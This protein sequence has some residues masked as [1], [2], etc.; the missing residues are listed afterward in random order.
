MA[1]FLHIPERSGIYQIVNT[2]TQR[3]YVGYASNMRQ[4]LKG[5]YHELA[6]FKHKN[7]YLQRS[8]QKYGESCFSISVLQECEKDKLCF[9]EDYWI[10]TLKVCNRQYG[11]NI[12]D[13][14]ING[15]AGQSEET[16]A[17]LR[18]S[19]K[20]ARPNK[21]AREKANLYWKNNPMTDEHKEKLKKSRSHINWKELYRTKRGKRVI[22]IS[23][24]KIYRSLA[25]AA[26][27]IN[28]TKYKLCKYLLGTRTNKTT[29]RY[30]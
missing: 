7:E 1:T 9:Y 19:N 29:L 25:E 4:R 22:D 5:H 11:Y 12:K 18:I 2:I 26:E 14:N 10:K 28:M 6:R 21:E 23:N 24:N 17:K 13:G 20:N 8:W 27:D 16:K 3:R 15:K 30:L